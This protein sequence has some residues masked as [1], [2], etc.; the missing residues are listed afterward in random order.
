MSKYGTCIS[1]SISLSIYLSI[2]LG[3]YVCVGAFKNRKCNIT[4]EN[5]MINI[6]YFL[7]YGIGVVLIITNI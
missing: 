3:V 6:F 7:L 1:L 5:L 2:P 4:N